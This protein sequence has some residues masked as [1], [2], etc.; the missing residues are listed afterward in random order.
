[1]WEDK[2]YYSFWESESSVRRLVAENEALVDSFVERILAAGTRV[3]GFSTHTTSFRVSLELARRLKRR[4]PSVLVLFG[5]PQ[6]SRAQAGRP[7]AEEPCVDAVIIGEGELTLTEV[8]RR[9]RDGK[10]LEPMPGLLMRHQGVVVDGGDRGVITDLDR[11]PLPDYSDFDAAIRGGL[12]AD[13]E[14]LEILDSRGCVRTCHFC[15]EWQFWR[16]FRAMSGERMFAEASAQVLRYPRVNRFYFIGSLVNGS[17]GSLE[18]FC[19]LVIASDLRIRWQGQAIVNPAM[20]DRLLGKMAR[21]GC[22]WLGFGI[23]SGSEDLRARMNKK[24][25]NENAFATLRA[26]HRAGIR[27]QINVMFG[28]PTETRRDFEETLRFLARVR[29]HIETV[30][31]SQS[32]AVIDKGTA[33]HAH[34]ERFG[35]SDQDHH[36]YWTSNEGENDYAERSRRYEEFCRVAIALGVPEVSGVLREKP[37]KWRLLGE[38]ALYRRDW[39][40]AVRALRRALRREPGDEGLRAG[41]ARARE[42]LRPAAAAA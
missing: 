26:A 17:I 29:P 42:E 5:G 4:D 27:A 34:P 6:C 1:M 28:L 30:L 31:A 18:R 35:V 21:A 33:P 32:F 9:A 40:G 13:P 11:L 14:R 39:R 41:L 22:E 25:T 7:F 15:S 2:D 24:F 10:P 16:S 23:E 20:D 8:L 36:L 38:H 3:A 19:D 12:Y 37:D